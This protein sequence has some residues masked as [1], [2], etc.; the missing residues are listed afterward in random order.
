MGFALVNSDR[1]IGAAGGR[2]S[3]IQNFQPISLKNS[4]RGIHLIP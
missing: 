3:T 1:R 4:I 2:S